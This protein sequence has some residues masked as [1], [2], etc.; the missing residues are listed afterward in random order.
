MTQPVVVIG[1]GIVGACCAYTLAKAG[2]QVS[3]VEPGEPGGEQA[4]SFGNGGWL[5]PASVVPMS[6]PGLLARVPRLLADREGPLTI[7]PGALLP[8]APWLWR[9]LRAGST[10]PKV[11]ATACRLA[12]LLRDAPQRHETLAAEVGAG[13]RVHRRGLLYPYVDAAAFE[14][15]AM[16]WRL[17]RDNGVA[18]RVLSAEERHRAAPGLS[19]RYAHLVFVPAGGHVDDPSAYVRAIVQAAQALGARRVHGR[20][21]G[22]ERE[23]GGR[24]AF[25]ALRGVRVTLDSGERVVIES[26]HAVLAAGLASGALAAALGARGSGVSLAGERGYHI[27]LPWRAGAVRTW[28]VPAMPA[29]GKMAVTDTPAGLRL[30]GQVELAAPGAAPDWRRADVLWRHAQRLLNDD[31]WQVLDIS[32]AQRMTHTRPAQATVWMGHRPSSTDSLPIV[33]PAPGCAGVVFAFGHGHVGLA[34]GPITAEQV[35]TC[36]AGSP[37]KARSR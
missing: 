24:G 13:A 6:T 1:A 23:P 4:A 17:R 10:H 28:P 11:Q 14:A 37:A 21:T 27:V 12:E 30:A 16:A 29:D 33:G 20:A 22:W 9:F 19:T 34:T 26:E 35:L 25:G 15:E 5:S 7:R 3:L 32:S 31:T 2:W 18:W 8:L 36:L